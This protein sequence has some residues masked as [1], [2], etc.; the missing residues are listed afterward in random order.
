LP[1]AGSS[2]PLLFNTLIREGLGMPSL[3]DQGFTLI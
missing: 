3:K 2:P 1:L